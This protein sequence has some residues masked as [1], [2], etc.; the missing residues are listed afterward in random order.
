MMPA[1]G[2][3]FSP[4]GYVPDLRYH[5]KPE[6]EILTILYART[7]AHLHVKASN[8]RHIKSKVRNTILEWDGVSRNQ[9]CD[10]ICL[11]VSGNRS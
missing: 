1:R 4:F 10:V 9:R 5:A 6:V 7:R 3:L 2:T 8:A 11:I